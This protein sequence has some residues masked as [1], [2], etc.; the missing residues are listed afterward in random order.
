MVTIPFLRQP[1]IGLPRKGPVRTLQ[2][3]LLAGVFAALPVQA[4]QRKALLPDGYPAKPVRVINSAG[5]GGGLDIVTRALASKISERV[6]VTLLV[7]NIA[8]AAGALAVN[9]A[10]AAAPDGYTLLSTGSTTL[11]NGVFRRFER[12]VRQ[13]LA[14]VVSMSSSYYFVIVPAQ[15]PAKSMAEFVA[16]AR[17]QPGKLNYGSPGIGSVI[18]LGLKMIETGLN[19]DMVHIPYK[20]V[21][22][23]NLD[24]AAGRLDVALVSLSGMQQVRAGKAR[25]LATSMPQR[26]AE[27]P[28]LPTLAE[29]GIPGYE[30]ANSYLIYAPAQTPAAIMN[31]LNQEAIEVLRAPDIRQ[32]LAA[33]GAIGSPPWNPP[34]LKKRFLADYARW[35]D[36][37]RKGN[38]QYQE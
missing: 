33:D 4:Q 35:E 28:D 6:G 22:P 3:L 16:L 2:A 18:H 37:I 21:A 26:A 30:V 9:A 11:I 1:D 25:A 29:A 7:D 20:A 32:K 5:A 17:A 38:I 31:A 10:A 14:P 23:I 13:S 24:I 19:L 15:S 8:G 34:E 27:Y 12:D 36:V